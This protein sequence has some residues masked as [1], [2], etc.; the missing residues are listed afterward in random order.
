MAY[1]ASGR[2]AL[3][4]NDNPRA[5]PGNNS[6]VI[7]LDARRAVFLAE[8]T[9]FAEERRCDEALSREEL[10]ALPPEAQTQAQRQSLL[11]NLG[12]LYARRPDMDCAPGVLSIVTFMAGNRDGACS[13]SAA[14][15]AKFLSRSERAVIDAIGRL[16]SEQA[17]IVERRPGTTSLLTPW[18]HRSFGQFRDALT[19]IMDVRAPS[20]ER[21]RPGRPRLAADTPEIPLKE[22]SPLFPDSGKD[23]ENQQEEGNTPEAV[24]TPEPSF[25]PEGGPQIPLKPA[26]YYMKGDMKDSTGLGLVADPE[27]GLTEDDFTEFHALC[28]SWGQRPNA[29]VLC[30][31]PRQDTDSQLRGAFRQAATL[32][33]P[34]KDT[35]RAAF[36]GALNAMRAAAIDDRTQDAT[37]KG[38]GAKS[39]MSYFRKT[40]ESEVSR[41]ILAEARNLAAA[42]SEKQIQIAV[43]Q[44]RLQGVSSPPKRSGGR[45][46]LSSLMDE[47]SDEGRD[48]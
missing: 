44:R 27:T 33:H 35:L 26:S 14:R 4:T 3:S 45:S 9:K 15:I 5:V 43:H 18:V 7:E 23:V 19:W 36:L 47:V 37:P 41:L 28:N 38:R 34:E 40:L 1:Q 22:A 20:A 17:L 46:S 16:E 2:S 39:A 29:I 48:N 30:P 24:F 13:L 21:A 25:T 11:D 10:S 12:H 8:L 6:G 31:W 42:E 32:Y